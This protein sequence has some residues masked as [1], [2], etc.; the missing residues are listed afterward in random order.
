M[1]REVEPLSERKEQ[2]LR[3][4]IVEYVT[5]A[6]PVPSDLIASK[7][8]LGVRSATVRSELSEMSD[9]G[10]LE[11][12]HTSAGRV[13]SDKGYRYFV[14]RLLVGTPLES[15]KRKRMRQATD[16]EDTL[17]EILRH[18]TRALSRLT[19]LLSAAATLRDGDATVR[20]SVL[21]VLG[22][23]RALLVVIL[24]NG[25]VE[26]R[27]V[28][29]P[30]GTTIEHVGR[31]NETL[32]ALTE[33]KTLRALTKVTAP[34][35]G[36][37]ATDKLAR[38]VC[39]VVKTVA[40]DLTKGQVVIEGEEYIF[41]QPEFQRDAQLLERLVA[42]LEDERT[43]HSALLEESDKFPAVTIGREHRAES[44]H[45]LSI[46]RQTFCVGDEEAG[47]IAIIGPTRMNY[48]HGIR[49]LDFT[50]LAIG[51][52]LTRLLR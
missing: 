38:A 18:T 31:V 29:L 5:G 28:E 32:A 11:Q 24:Q 13:P 9:L 30:K 35:T 50:A 20:N 16:E 1:G 44:M 39:A 47:T 22:P 8:E 12:P 21:T 41:A 46:V 4:V 6:E 52:T 25:L 2:I 49:L 40:R 33:R 45:P 37:P 7:Y 15:E 26:N 48:E 34:S 19:H 3:A 17:Q 43:I 10:Y 27:V 36:D 42:S 14:D 23:Q 51:E